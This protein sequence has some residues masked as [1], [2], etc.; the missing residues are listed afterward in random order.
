MKL[1]G[2]NEEKITKY[3]N[4]ETVPHLQ[5][6]KVVLVHCK[7]VNNNCQLTHGSYLQKNP[8]K[9]NGQLTNISPT[10]CICNET[11]RSEFPYIEVSLQRNKR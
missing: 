11:F 8:S 6:I 10:N 1:L 3:K 9:S 2:S 7:F 5:N 4:S